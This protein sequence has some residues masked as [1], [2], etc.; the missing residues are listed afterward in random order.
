[1]LVVDG[2]RF[3]LGKHRFLKLILVPAVADADAA[4]HQ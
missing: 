2:N 3:D 1:M 4:A